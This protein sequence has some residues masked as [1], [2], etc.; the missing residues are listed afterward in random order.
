MKKNAALL[1]ALLVT[2]LVGCQDGLDSVA[3]DGDLVSFSYRVPD[4]RT[5]QGQ[6]RLHGQ[7]IIYDRDIL[8]PVSAMVGAGVVPQANYESGVKLWDEF[9][10]VVW[11]RFDANVSADVRTKVKNA[12]KVWNDIGFRIMEWGR[13]G[14]DRE[15]VRVTTAID[16]LY[17][18]SC[19]AT[20]GRGSQSS[21]SGIVNQYAAGSRCTMH[22]YIHEWGHILGLLHETDRS[23]RDQYLDIIDPYCIDS[24]Y[25]RSF[26]AYDFDS[27]MHYD[28]YNRDADGNKTNICFRPK[29]STGRGI[30]SIGFTER[31][32][33]GDIAVMNFL[34]PNRP[35]DRP[36]PR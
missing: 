16:P 21:I 13:G 18:W 36:I 6:G 33:A 19:Y 25:G 17:E 30:D 4:G 14:K 10:G 11:Y 9:G 34:Y 7:F 29:P 28:A 15:Y 8:I 24:T 22:D 27:I 23:D 32:S 1:I 35:Y 31:L 12:A 5:L 3:T 20:I 26:G 2:L